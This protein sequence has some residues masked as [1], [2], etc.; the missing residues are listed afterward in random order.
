MA[1]PYLVRRSWATLANGARVVGLAA[2][3]IV[4][5]GNY[6][7]LLSR[8]CAAFVSYLTLETSHSR[9]QGKM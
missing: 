9:W 7:R 4:V 1:C 2:R 3:A 8:N 6:Q 5:N